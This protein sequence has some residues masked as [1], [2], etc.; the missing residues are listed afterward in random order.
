MPAQSFA[1]RIKLALS[2]SCDPA[3]ELEVSLSARLT[4]LGIALYSQQLPAES[5]LESS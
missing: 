1:E 2:A 4:N 3:L 5:W